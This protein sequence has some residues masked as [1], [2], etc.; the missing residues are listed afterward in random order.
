MNSQN[1]QTYVW[2]LLATPQIS[3]INTPY[4]GWV[5]WSNLKCLS[6]P[7]ACAIVSINECPGFDFNLIEYSLS[8]SSPIHNVYEHFTLREWW[9]DSC[10][11]D[12]LDD[13]DEMMIRKMNSMT[14]WTNLKMHPTMH[15]WMR[16]K[17]KWIKFSLRVLFFVD[18]TPIVKWMDCTRT[19]YHLV[20][21]NNVI[22][23][24]FL[25]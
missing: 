8:T 15:K 3:L 22:T 1:A 4:V 16:P 9:E 12:S 25:F 6:L 10:D 11:D 24:G 5:V 17:I 14:S 23:F 13:D 19:G 20:F 7:A 18:Y 2:L 21:K